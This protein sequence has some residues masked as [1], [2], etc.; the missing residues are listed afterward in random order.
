MIVGIFRSEMGY[1]QELRELVGHRP[2]VLVGAAVLV[3]DQQGRILMNL[4]SDNLQWGIPGGATEPGE[5]IE[6]TALR[7]VK[8]ETG[9]DLE[10][11]QL[12]GVF[13]GPELFYQ[14]PNGDIVHNVSIVF[15]SRKYRGILTPSDDESQRLEFNRPNEIHLD[16]V[17]PPVRPILI[18]WLKVNTK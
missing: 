17:S 13:S 12:F 8:E 1:I 11:L 15:Q 9:L 5:K 4:R 14:Y 7:E 6:D 2:L 10:D 16:Q 3:V 18:Q